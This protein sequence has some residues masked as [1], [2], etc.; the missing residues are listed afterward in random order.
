MVDFE[1]DADEYDLEFDF[2]YLTVEGNCFFKRMQQL[3][4]KIVNICDCVPEHVK[5]IAALARSQPCYLERDH[6]TWI[7]PIAN[8]GDTCFLTVTIS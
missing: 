6:H 7:N 1:D 2:F 8:H 5:E 3:Y 4:K